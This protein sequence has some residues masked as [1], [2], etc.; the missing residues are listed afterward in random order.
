[1]KNRLIDLNDHLFAEIERLSDEST[2]GDELKSEIDRA[3]AVASVAKQIIDGAS[4]ALKAQIALAEREIPKLPVM[5]G[6]G[7]SE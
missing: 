5:L 3:H 1:M 6:D 4:L 2:Q 7:S